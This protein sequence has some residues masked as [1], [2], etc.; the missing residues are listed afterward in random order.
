MG[1]GR[2]LVSRHPA[3][4]L[5]RIRIEQL[6]HGE[7]RAHGDRGVEQ[8]AREVVHLS[9]NLDATRD[10]R[11]SLSGQDSSES[12]SFCSERRAG[13]ESVTVLRPARLKA[14]LEPPHAL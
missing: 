2:A 5:Q 4:D 7:R 14:A 6:R 10:Q 13:V 1:C 8:E 12:V 9:W 11:M 3:I